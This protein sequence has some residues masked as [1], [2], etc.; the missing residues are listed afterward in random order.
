METYCS[1][2]KKCLLFVG[3]SDGRPCPPYHDIISS[4]INQTSIYYNMLVF[5]FFPLN[6]NKIIQGHINNELEEIRLRA[7][8][9]LVLKFFK[10]DKVFDYIVTMEDILQTLTFICNNSIYSYQNQICNGFITINGGHRV[11]ITGSV[12]MENNKI[13]NINYISS[14]NFRISKQIIGCSN[15]ILKYVLDSKNNT[16]YNTLIVSPPGSRKNHITARLSKNNKC[17]IN[18]RVSG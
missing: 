17:E 16:V 4:K 6:I 8:R 15:K 2:F 1:C 18:S 9:P 10:E 14:L 7:N 11:G 3:Q 5:N 12:V 13:I